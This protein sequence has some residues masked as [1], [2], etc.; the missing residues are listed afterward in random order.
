MHTTTSKAVLTPLADAVSTL[1]VIVSDAETDSTA[2]PNLSPLARGVEGQIA[3]LVNVGKKIEAQ[4]S[5]DAV[6]QRDMPKA[7]A[8]V[9]KSAALLVSAT[10]ALVTDPYSPK[11]RAD[12]LHAV[13]G[14]LSGTT[15]VLNVFD[16]AEVRKIL[17]ACSMLR[18]HLST[19]AAGPV[20]PS[21]IQAF[22]QV[23]AQASQT[24][25]VLAQLT[26]KR[27]GELLFLVLQTRLKA[28]IS[29]LT[30]ESPVLIGA[31]KLG[32]TQP[33]NENAKTSRADTCARLVDA[34]KE[35]EVVVQFTTEDEGLAIEGTSDVGKV[36]K[37]MTENLA[38]KVLRAI[39]SEKPQEIQR[40]VEN[41]GRATEA[42]VQHAQ[43]F[44]YNVRDSA[45]RAQ[46]EEICAE[47][48]STQKS[49]DKTA[50]AAIDTSASTLSSSEQAASSAILRAQA[51]RVA[52]RAEALQTAL[53]RA[54]ISDAG[55]V[56]GNLST[57]TARGT[58]LNRVHV[59][60]STGK[61]AALADDLEVFGGESRRLEVVVSAAI[62]SVVVTNPQMAQELRIVRDRIK[63]LSVAYG[64]AARLLVENPEDQAAQAHYRA[65]SGAW[66]ESVKDIQKMM[67]GQEGV[68]KAEEII[69]GTK[70]GFEHHAR[71]LAGVAAKGNVV[72]T[73]EHAALLV[74]SANQFIAVAQREVENTED[75]AYKGDLEAK[76]HEIQTGIPDFLHSAQLVLDS[77]TESSLDAARELSAVV[78][79]LAQQLAG[80]GDV[81]RSYKGGAQDS[82]V[83]SQPPPPQSPQWLVSGLHTDAAGQRSADSD[84]AKPP[85]SPSDPVTAPLEEHKPT[86]TE[87]VASD[88]KPAKPTITIE[89]ITEEMKD[90]V[91]VEEEKPMLL[92]EEEAAASPIKAAAQELKVV[93]SN[94][95]ALENPIVAAVASMSASLGDLG[96]LHVDMRRRPTPAMKKAFIESAKQITA[97]SVR[98]CRSS[99]A[100]VGVCKDKRLTRQLLATVDRIETLA[101]QLKIVAAVK[102]STPEDRDQDALLVQ[103]ANNIMG[104]VKA[105]LLDSESASLRVTPEALEAIGVRFRRQVHRAKQY[106]H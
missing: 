20:N 101:L 3:N 69:S 11:G 82:L 15:Q 49:L 4:P 10:D 22:V 59:A 93:A 28:A 19:I 102:A 44:G 32:L 86:D 39:A 16:D 68:F 83:E 98:V 17:N 70:S 36:R 55:S 24:I 81:I 33:G 71:S 46:I 76:I 79:G 100:L 103:C 106:D 89:E 66:E 54:V 95:V 52:G 62:D 8:D 48:S 78:S 41:Q 61:V 64:G 43:E 57:L 99:K 74:T 2:M 88:T 14:I 72:A 104:A 84:D 1:I 42:L 12:L 47:L 6:L 85:A 53:T 34:V 40:A 97:E 21:E 5:A 35:I 87:N 92:S 65:V 29:L 94:W 37:A 96:L 90:C 80:L 13:K 63:G 9:T 77:Y 30:K 56:L 91:I 23:I 38:P 7:C 27:V 25:V 26:S 60:A 45:Q 58:V 51:T 50:L 75:E 73:R 18:T 31:C 67:I 105:A